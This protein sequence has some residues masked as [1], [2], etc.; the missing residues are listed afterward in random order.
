MFDVI[1]FRNLPP[2][3]LVQ[4][5]NSTACQSA[6]TKGSTT[7]ILILIPAAG[8]GL[9]YVFSFLWKPPIL[10]AWRPREVRAPPRSQ[11]IPRF[12]DPKLSPALPA[13][14]S[15]PLRAPKFFAPSAAAPRRR[16]APTASA[17]APAPASHRGAAPAQDLDRAA[18]DP[19][20][21]TVVSK[22]YKGLGGS[23]D[24]AAYYDEEDQLLI[25]SEM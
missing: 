24:K 11:A 20:R 3:C 8:E 19:S 13:L 12:P 18:M 23:S 7:H 21:D 9:A 17:P 25:K 15:P 5:C 4:H 6:N 14:S 2:P 10:I 1:A 16:E 22:L